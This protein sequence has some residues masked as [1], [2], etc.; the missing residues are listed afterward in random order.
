MITLISILAP[1]DDQ[2]NFGD[3]YVTR[4]EKLSGNPYREGLSIED[5]LHNLNIYAQI[6]KIYVDFFTEYWYEDNVEKTNEMMKERLK[7]A[8]II[9]WSG[10]TAEE[11]NPLG[12]YVLAL[13]LPVK[14][15]DMETFFERVRCGDLEFLCRYCKTEYATCAWDLLKE[16]WRN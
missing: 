4:M 11:N 1:I 12:E 5:Y 15:S 14:R 2:L 13:D 6:M 10:L 8:G 3:N 9:G 16:V 7:K